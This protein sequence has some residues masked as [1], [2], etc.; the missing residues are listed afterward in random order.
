MKRCYLAALRA[1]RHL[2]ARLIFNWTVASDGGV[3]DLCLARSS[4]DPA[5]EIARCLEE[6]IRT[7]RWDPPP[8]GDM[9]VTYQFVFNAG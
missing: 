3:R 6:K 1:D 2:S 8:P 4:L 5:A 9:E 7:W